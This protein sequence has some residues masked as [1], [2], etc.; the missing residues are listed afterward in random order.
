MRNFLILA[1]LLAVVQTTNA[2]SD[3]INTTLVDPESNVAFIGIENVFKATFA[4]H[5]DYEVKSNLCEI[6]KSNKPNQF[7]EKPH[8]VGVDTFSIIQ[9]GKTIFE[10]TIKLAYLPLPKTVLGSLD[11]KT[12]SAEDII[13]ARDL[14]VK[15]TNCQCIPAMKVRGYTLN[16]KRKNTGKS[17]T[18]IM[19]EG[20]TLLQHCIDAIRLLSAGDVVTFDQIKAKDADNG[21]VLLPSFSIT[22]R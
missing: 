4:A 6:Q 11:E 8:A 15:I 21:P 19:V 2:Q 7:I 12:A 3:L 16:I 13:A 22:I 1:T 18:D 20:N 17:D 10:K 14:Q 9:N 5:G